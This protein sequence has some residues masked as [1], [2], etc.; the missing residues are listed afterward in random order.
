MGLYY[1]IT[2]ELNVTAGKAETRDA[3]AEWQR[4]DE[5]LVEE[6]GRWLNRIAKAFVILTFAIFA[7]AYVG[8]F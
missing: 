8:C 5:D 6:F 3:V 4:W 2:E 1:E 7:A